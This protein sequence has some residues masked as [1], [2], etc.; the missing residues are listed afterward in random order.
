M[1][2]TLKSSNFLTAIRILAHKHLPGAEWREWRNGMIVIVIV[3]ID[4]S[5]IPYYAREMMREEI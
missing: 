2:F 3:I 1:Y 5:P 4:H